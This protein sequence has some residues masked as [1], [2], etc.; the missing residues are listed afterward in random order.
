M[1]ANLKL[2][3][4][5]EDD[6]LKAKKPHF[7]FSFL[8]IILLASISFLAISNIVDATMYMVFV[9]LAT[10]PVFLYLLFLKAKYPF[11]THHFIWLHHHLAISR[12]YILF[13]SFIAY[14]AI[15]FFLPPLLPEVG[16]TTSI[17]SF[18]LIDYMV[19][20]FGLLP[21][22]AVIF[23]QL[24]TTTISLTNSAKGRIIPSFAQKYQQ[25]IR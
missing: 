11:A 3:E 15:F 7:I 10:I 17:S 20:L 23:I 19:M 6:N 21:V 4:T 13:M 1:E 2:F 8:L 9:F 22:V 18:S 12:F 25:K 16:S 24:V 14:A 5:T